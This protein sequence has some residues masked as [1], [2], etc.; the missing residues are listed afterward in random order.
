MGRVMTTATADS[1]LDRASTYLLKYLHD[2]TSAVWAVTSTPIGTNFPINGADG[3]PIAYLSLASDVPVPSVYNP[4]GTAV[5]AALGALS[6]VRVSP[7]N[8]DFTDVSPLDAVLGHGRVIAYFQPIVELGTCHVVA[9]E[10]LA[11]WQTADGVLGPDAFLDTLDAHDLLLELFERMVDG[12]LQFLS[13]RRHWMPDLNVAVN[14]DL[15]TVPKFG[16]AELLQRLLEMHDIRAD[17]LTI[18][19]NDAAGVEL[20]VEQQR[21]LRRAA[22]MGVH[23]VAGDFTTTWDI[24]GVPIAGAK[25]N[26]RFVSTLSHGQAEEAV[27]SIMQRAVDSELTLIAEGVETQQQCEHL[28]QLGC[29]FGQGYF[30]AVPQSPGSLDAVLQAPL[31]STW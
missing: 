11:R 25:L 29:K 17:Q 27:R 1:A 20:H 10:T 22:D 12:A 24:V 21:E 26:R 15:R 13:D 6:T 30:F 14:L 9:L 8:F 19:L 2:E 31:A 3:A 4:I 23:L 18:E 28:K 7:R 5:A 16:L